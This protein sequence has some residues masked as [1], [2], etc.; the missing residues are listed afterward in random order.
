MRIRVGFVLLLVLVGVAALAGGADGQNHGAATERVET[1][2]PVTASSPTATPET[3]NAADE[4]LTHPQ[5]HPVYGQATTVFTL[6]F[7]LRENAG[8][9]GILATDYRAQLTPPQSA[10]ACVD[11]QPATIDSGA[12]GEV[13]EI[14]LAPPAGGWCRGTHSVAI[15][16]QRGPYC[17]PPQEG[18]PP[19]PC[20]EF[21]TQDLETG[22]TAFTVGATGAPPPMVTVPKLKGLRPRAANRR[23]RRRHLRVHYTALSNLCAGIP[24]HG[25]IILQQPRAGARVPRGTRV[26]AQTSCG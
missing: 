7:T 24:P 16:L 21:A 4:E 10:A 2:T 18:A 13:R 25:R 20:P 26:L 15:F 22:S 11:A 8:H 3:T 17:P 1:A 12:A 5:V 6:T 9:E 14:A 23:L 19:T